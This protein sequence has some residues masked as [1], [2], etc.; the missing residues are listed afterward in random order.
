MKDKRNPVLFRVGKGTGTVIALF[1]EDSASPG[2]CLS[3]KLVPKPVVEQM[4]INYRMAIEMS[5]PAKTEELQE[6]LKAI[7]D[8]G[9]AP[10]IRQ[11]Y[12]RKK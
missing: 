4:V 1:P 5:R 9:M 12:R 7:R 2:Y 8:M 10:V 6:L 3:F 11:K